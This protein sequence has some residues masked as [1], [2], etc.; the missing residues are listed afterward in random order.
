MKKIIAILLI[1][2]ALFPTTA[3]CDYYA[4][5]VMVFQIDYENDTFQAIDFSKSQF[6]TFT[7]IEDYIVGDLISM[8]MDDKN[9]NF[10]FDDEV[11]NYRYVGWTDPE[12]WLDE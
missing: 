9:T 6:H 7:E 10:I 2:I 5:T 3:L 1:L 4:F 12:T 8:V 11:I